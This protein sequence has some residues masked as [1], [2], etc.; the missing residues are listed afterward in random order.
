MVFRSDRLDLEGEVVTPDGPPL[1]IAVLCHGIPSG[2]APEPDDA[3]YP[4]LARTIAAAG[5]AAMWFDFRGCRGAPGDFS[6][7]GWCADLGAALDGL[8]A[9]ELGVPVAVVGSSAGGAVAV[10][11][12]AARSDVAA[13][14]TLAAPASF[15]F[16][17]LVGDARAFLQDLRNRGIVRDPAFPRDLDEWAA[18]LADAAADRHAAAI[19]PRAML[20]VH[21][22]ADDVVPYPHAERLFEAAGEPK[23]LVRIPRGGHQLRRDPRAV[24][25]VLDWLERR[26]APAAVRD[27]GPGRD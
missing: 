21:G 8:S 16:G 14:A 2:R 26:L 10:A 19:A 15:S 5:F 12:A 23:E 3:G 4:G 25:A 6:I 27:P 7:A 17:D 22:D 9:L 18:E 1:A 24:A 11:V 13:V 20:V